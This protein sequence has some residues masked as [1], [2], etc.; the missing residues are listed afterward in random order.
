MGFQVFQG[1][2]DAAHRVPQQTVRVNVDRNAGTIELPGRGGNLQVPRARVFVNEGSRDVFV[3]YTAGGGGGAATASPGAGGTVSAGQPRH[4]RVI[5][6]PN[7][8]TGIDTPFRARLPRGDQSGPQL[9]FRLS[10]C[11]LD[12]FYVVANDTA[13][14]GRSIP[15]SA[16]ILAVE[17]YK[18]VRYHSVKMQGASGAQPFQMDNSLTF[19]HTVF[20]LDCG[21]LLE[22]IDERT[23][24]HRAR[25]QEGQMRSVAGV[26]SNRDGNEIWV[27]ACDRLRSSRDDVVGL[28]GRGIATLA[29]GQMVAMMQ[30]NQQNQAALRQM[31]SGNSMMAWPT[32]C[33]QQ[34]MGSNTAF[35]GLCMA[36]EGHTPR[37]ILVRQVKETL[38]HE[39]GHTF[40][41]VPT[42]E[43]AGG[44]SRA[45]WHDGGHSGHC[46]NRE[47]AMYWTVRQGGISY[48]RS[49]NHPPEFDNN[50]LLGLITAPLERI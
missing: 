32:A 45:N 27:M 20:E 40:T 5:R 8:T 33:S 17:V 25:V 47:C 18:R 30:T 44:H 9:E 3:R 39:L 11:G 37:E 35:G 19:A 13:M 4:F 22:R 36:L 48:M 46:S 2:V 38:L 50:C 31:T 14:S 49:H 12:L 7:N 6:D 43:M 41:M 1:Q 42:N 16:A 21:I 10:Q 29:I 28:G 23:I 24:N 34:R 15:S 26:Q